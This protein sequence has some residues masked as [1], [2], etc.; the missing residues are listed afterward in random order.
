MGPRTR[1]HLVPRRDSAKGKTSG[2]PPSFAGI[3]VAAAKAG[4]PASNAGRLLVP[5]ASATAAA[6]PTLEELQRQIA[7]LRRERKA[8]KTA[9]STLTEEL[10]VAKEQSVAL[11]KELQHAH[12]KYTRGEH[13]RYCR[14]R[15][16][17]ALPLRLASTQ[18]CGQPC[19]GSR[20]VAC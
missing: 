17:P 19:G 15:H 18:R 5:K 20:H 4:S 16:D 13:R 6:E 12:N 14:A 10:T 3:V 7:E 1:R 8:D 9:I 11:K 2:A